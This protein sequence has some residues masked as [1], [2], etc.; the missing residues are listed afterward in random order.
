MACNLV[1]ENSTMYLLL[2]VCLSIAETID[3]VAAVV[4]DEVITL[5]DVYD[6]G[7]D[8][9]ASAQPNIRAAEI[10]V[11]DSLIMRKLIEQEVVRLGQDVTEEELI[12]SNCT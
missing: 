8:Y 5:S 9:I 4:N 10:E 7:S 2:W 12:R 1:V 3:R 11:L 6:I